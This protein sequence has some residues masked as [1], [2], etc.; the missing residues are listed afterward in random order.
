MRYDHLIGAGFD[1]WHTGKYSEAQ[2]EALAE[3]SAAYLLLSG[4]YRA[5]QI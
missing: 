5:R 3:N 4:S 1:R 2:I